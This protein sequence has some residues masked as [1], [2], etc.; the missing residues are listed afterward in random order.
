MQIDFCMNMNHHPTTQTK[1]S[2]PYMAIKYTDHRLREVAE[3]P[4][5][6]GHGFHIP[7]NN[8][9]RDQPGRKGGGG[10]RISLGGGIP[11]NRDWRYEVRSIP[12][13]APVIAAT[14]AIEV[15]RETVRTQTP[16]VQTQLPVYES[17]V[18]PTGFLNL[19]KKLRVL[20]DCQIGI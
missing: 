9:R 2:T 4:I 16:P 6:G 20:V 18:M 17:T 10:A 19:T 3:A 15:L 13:M 5:G 12:K 11:T 1:K 14:P 7:W 8:D